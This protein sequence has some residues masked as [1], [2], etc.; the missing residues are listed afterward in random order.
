M[1]QVR[2]PPKG[3][4]FINVL[5]ITEIFK[6]S[7][8]SKHVSELLISHLHLL[9]F[10]DSFCEPRCQLVLTLKRRKTITQNQNK[11]SQ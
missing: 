9:V 4:S 8:V 2:Q 1:T 11:I 6:Q 3:Q 7:E 5:C 10:A